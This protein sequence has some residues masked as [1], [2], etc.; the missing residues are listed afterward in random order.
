MRHTARQI[1][2]DPFVI[3]VC[4]IVGDRILSGH[5]YFTTL[6]PPPP[7]PFLSSR[8]ARDVRQMYEHRL[9]HAD[10]LYQKLSD[11]KRQLDSRELELKR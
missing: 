9:E 5:D 3:P 6:L 7:F 4:Y 8:H 2:V 1:S 11:C 10:R